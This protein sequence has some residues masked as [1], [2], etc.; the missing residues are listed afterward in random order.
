VTLVAPRAHD[1]PADAPETRPIMRFSCGTLHE[2]WYVAALSSEVSGTRPLARTI[3]EEPIVLFRGKRGQAVALIDRCLHRNAQ[4]S[5]GRVFDGCIGCPYHGWTYGASG[6]CVFVPSEGPGAKPG[7]Q[8]RLERFPVREQDGLV[9]VYLGTPERAEE[10]EPFG[11]PQ[12]GDGWRSYFMVTEF[13]GAVTDLVENFMDVPHTAFVHSGWFRKA[14]NAKPAEAVVERTPEGVFVEYF[15]PDDSIGFARRLLNPDGKPL[16]HTDRF[17]MP[18]VTRV[19]YLW[20]ERRGFVITSQITPVTPDRALVYTA[21][22]FRFG[23]VFN[24]LARALLPPYTRA[25]IR[26][27]VRIMAVQTENLRRFGRPRFHSTAADAIHEAIEALR[28]HA[29][30]GGPGPAPERRTER[31]SFWM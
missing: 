20:G 11:F 5:R 10:R 15:Q 29:E 22:T 25:V 3:L 13:D 31:I 7:E 6:R 12:R 17:Y 8:R 4:L 16:V 27:D 9:W 30:G 26:Q 14:A 24:A 2:H 19:D 1:R 23:R 28:L 18:N 21:I